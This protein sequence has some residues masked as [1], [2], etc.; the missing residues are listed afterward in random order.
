VAT[1]E[2]GS[3]WQV[4][5]WLV[6]PADDTIS[7]GSERTKL[8]PRTMRLLVCLVESAGTVV[9]IDQLLS[10]VWSGVVVGPASVYQSVSQLRKLLGDTGEQPTYIATV[11]RKGYRLVASAQ[12]TSHR[13]AM[14]VAAST[15]A[16]FD[17]PAKSRRSRIKLLGAAVVLATLVSI[18]WLLLANYL[19]RPVAPTTIA[20]LPFVDMTSTKSDQPFCDGLTEELSSWLAQLPTLRVVARTSA[21]AFKDKAIDVREVGAQ[22]G[23]T[24]VLEGS[25]RRSG[26]Q[27]RVT[28]Q[29][30][31]TRDGYHLWSGSYDAKAAD[32]ISVQEQIARS[33]ASS[34][35]IRLTQSDS[36]RM[37]ARASGNAR[38]YQLY[39][40]A[41]FHRWQL[42][43][44]DN[45][46]AIEL[47]KQAIAADPEF[48]LAQV[49]LANSYVN[50]R[51]FNDRAIADIAQDVWPILA[52]AQKLNDKL[53]E[54]Y[55]VRAALHTEL[56]QPQ[57]AFRDLQRAIELS[58]N[59]RDA[60]AVLGLHYLTSGMPRDALL[61]FT[62]ASTLDPLD[63]NLHAERC[64]ALQDMARFDEA[65]FACERAR[66]LR[67]EAPW[68][69]TVSAQMAAAKGE[70]DM[71]LSW[72]REAI[73]RSSEPIELLFQRS[74]LLL[75]LG[76]VDDARDTYSNAMAAAGGGTGE[77]AGLMELGFATALAA[78]GTRALR[79]QIASV[80]IEGKTSA[81]TLMKLAYS[82]LL[83]GDAQ[84]AR[85]RLDEAMARGVEGNTLN[86]AWSARTGFS[87]QIVAA[88]TE[89]A[90]GGESSARVRLQ[91][92]EQMIVRARAA[93]M[94]RA[95]LYELEAQT[96]ALSGKHDKAMLALEAAAR[97]GWRDTWRARHEPYF[98][99]LSDRKDYT[100]LIGR[101]DNIIADMRAKA[102]A[103]DISESADRSR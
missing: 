83:A 35:E 26:D 50:Q 73:K 84:T 55:V 7:R 47:Y 70:L 53:P 87:F 88:A 90:T 61:S 79:Q 5:D 93:G 14:P 102:L 11:A 44:D 101:V 8:E 46:R 45:Q 22:L 24:H 98:L 103:G 15:I 21:F 92:I 1:V 62:K 89:L 38:A 52:G 41:R 58:P 100:A 51:Y 48:A 4:G 16:T 78:G 49:G 25:V 32:V 34:L 18:A 80:P 60:H 86:S 85:Q 82:E 19:H 71:A 39:L 10:Q 66:S 31:S 68:P 72:N 59:S 40:L 77:S 3:V 64:L 95:G 96:A 33:I 9:T 36:S 20:V 65:A 67:P 30:I 69:Y 76:L 28:V 13:A 97:L 75:I 29:L 81:M 12:L 94:Q 43:R 27:L 56:L 74:D 63:P 37:F 57:D 42:N 91:Q 6:D 54:L 23:T 2:P 99:S 17:T